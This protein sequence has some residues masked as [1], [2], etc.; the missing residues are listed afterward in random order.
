MPGM[1]RTTALDTRRPVR[2][3]Y[4]E[5]VVAVETTDT[6]AEAARRMARRRVGALIVFEEGE[7]KGIF[8]EADLVTAASE[9]ADLRLTP[10]EEFMTPG[11]FTVSPDE[12]VG[13][14][15]VRMRSRAIHHLP[16]VEAGEVVGML[17]LGDI[18]A[19]TDVLV[20][21]AART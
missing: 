18:L 1:A 16:V 21:G 15:A 20:P 11:A 10:V 14:A 5:E 12:Q 2:G 17:S 6:L 8:S 13:D 4:N 9:G 3:V 19:V 7:L